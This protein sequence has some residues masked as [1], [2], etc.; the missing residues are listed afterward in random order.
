MYRRTNCSDKEA[1]YLACGSCYG[2]FSGMDMT[3]ENPVDDD[4]DGDACSGIVN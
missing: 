3:W 4:L 2:S 1:E